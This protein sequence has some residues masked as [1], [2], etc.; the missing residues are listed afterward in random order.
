MVSVVLA[1]EELDMQ[2]F[3]MMVAECCRLPTTIMNVCV[4]KTWSFPTVI[5]NHYFHRNDRN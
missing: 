3:P 1:M 2:L 4:F 5:L